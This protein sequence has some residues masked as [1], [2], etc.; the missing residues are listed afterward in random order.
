VFAGDR[1]AWTG[2]AGIA[3]VIVLPGLWQLAGSGA[4]KIGEMFRVT[5]PPPPQTYVVLPKA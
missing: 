5:P 4:R 2:A 1:P 3:A